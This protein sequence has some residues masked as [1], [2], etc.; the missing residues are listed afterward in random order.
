MGR[1][2]PVGPPGQGN[3]D[4]YDEENIRQELKEYEAQRQKN[5]SKAEEENIKEEVDNK[6]EEGQK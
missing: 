4:E 2:P 5:Y 6:S 1:R 3:Y